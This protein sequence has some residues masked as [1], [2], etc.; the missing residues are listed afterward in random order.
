MSIVYD[1]DGQFDVS[2]DGQFA[3]SL[4]EKADV[5]LV[6]EKLPQGLKI[7]A[8]LILKGATQQEIADKT[9]LNQATISRRVKRIKQI[10]PLL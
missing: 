6:L 9:G 5:S 3:N 7:V 1:E 2:D 4:E 10:V 8:E